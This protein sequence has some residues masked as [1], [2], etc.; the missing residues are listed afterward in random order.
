VTHVAIRR[1]RK[2]GTERETKMGRRRI[3]SKVQESPELEI[4]K[5]N[6]RVVMKDDG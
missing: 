1:G 2:K 4:D 5:G 3:N 6:G